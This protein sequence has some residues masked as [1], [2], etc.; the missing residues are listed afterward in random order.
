MRRVRFWLF[1]RRR[2]A[3]PDC[4]RTESTKD[5]Q[6]ACVQKLLRLLL[7]ERAVHALHMKQSG[8]PSSSRRHCGLS[9]MHFYVHGPR[10]L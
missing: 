2:P 6:D 8:D 5:K 3:L 1:G 10:V 9:R 4:G 7:P